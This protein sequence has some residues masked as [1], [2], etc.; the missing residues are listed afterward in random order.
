MMPSGANLA[1]YNKSRGLAFKQAVA[2]YL[3]QAGHLSAWPTSPSKVS[4]HLR[5][6]GDIEG[7]PF[8]LSVRTAQ[9]YDFSSLLDEARDLANFH[10]RR[11]HAAIHARRGRELSE[12][13]VLLP[14][15]EFAELMRL[16]P[17]D[18]ETQ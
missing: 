15:S 2:L 1:A 8:A 13:F 16:V 5:T 12:A 17:P 10:G 11:W 6:C 7:T 4:D 9:S 18:E 3:I 14:L